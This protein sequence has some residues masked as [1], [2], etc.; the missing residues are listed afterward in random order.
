MRRLSP[1]PRRARGRG[2]RPPAPAPAGRVDLHGAGLAAPPRDG[3]QE[4]RGR[5]GSP[6]TIPCAVAGVGRL[7]EVLADFLA[8]AAGRYPDLLG[9]R[10]ERVTPEQA[11]LRMDYRPE[12][13]M[14]YGQLHGGAIASLADTAAGLV[15]V[16]GLA[17]GQAFTTVELKL[18]LLAP[19]REGT[20]TAVA[21]PVHRGRRTA[22][23][24]VRVDRADGRPVAWF[25]CTQLI[26]EA[27]P[28]GG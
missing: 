21:V 11:V 4:A 16:A 26:L 27:P 9:I 19:V 18:N 7:S 13:T 12:L 15:T 17:P 1:I 22:V 8:R 10:V 23:I 28:A 6:L 5:G 20:V 2:L 3:P 25:A 14:P 24:H